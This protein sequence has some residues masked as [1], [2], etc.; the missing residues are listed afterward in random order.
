MAEEN[1]IDQGMKIL[2]RKY[3]SSFLDLIFRYKCDYSLKVIEDP[4]LNIPEKRADS[5]YILEK[6]LEKLAIHIDFMRNV[7]RQSLPVMEGKTFYRELK[8]VKAA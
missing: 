3:P 4:V 5:I 8:G 1:P 2:A 7:E 6:N